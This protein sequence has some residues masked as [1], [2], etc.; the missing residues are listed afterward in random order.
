MFIKFPHA[1]NMPRISLHLFR[2]LLPCCSSCFS[3]LHPSNIVSLSRD[4]GKMASFRGFSCC[5]CRAG[6]KVPF[7]SLLYAHFKILLS[8]LPLSQAFLSCPQ[9]T[10]E[11]SPIIL[12]SSSTTDT[13]PLTVWKQGRN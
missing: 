9:S 6:G 13:L 1:G 12:N 4:S 3:L 10:S 2:A 5:C 8:I 11:S 7:S